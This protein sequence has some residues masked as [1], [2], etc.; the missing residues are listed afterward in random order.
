ML[1]VASKYV[2]KLNNNKYSINENASTNPKPIWPSRPFEEYT[3]I[4]IISAFAIDDRRRVEV[5]IS[6]DVD[7]SQRVVVDRGRAWR[8]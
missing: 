3:H 7:V 5:E 8:V 4:E 2:Q 6:G 1:L